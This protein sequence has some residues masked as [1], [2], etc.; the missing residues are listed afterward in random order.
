MSTFEGKAR[1]EF[2]PKKVGLFAAKV[3]AINPTA[4]E[5]PDLLGWPAKEDS[6]ETEYLGEDEEGNTKLRVNVWIEDVDTGT[7]FN[8]AFFL[9]NKERENKDFTK[10]QFINAVGACTWSADIRDLK[11]DETHKWFTKFEHRVAFVGEEELYTFIQS[12]LSRL[13]Y[14]SPETNLHIDDNWRMLMKGNVKFLKEQIG[15]EWCTDPKTG[16]AIPFL[17]L[18]TIR[19][20]D[21]DGETKEYQG[22][23]N[24]G[25]LPIRD[26]PHFRLTDYS[27]E[28]AVERIKAKNAKDRKRHEKFVLNLTGQYGCKDFYVLKELKDYDPS[29]NIVASDKVISEEG[30]DY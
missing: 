2:G 14:R 8:A 29:E 4:D 19:N 28:E 13:D 1:E 5:Y 10:K 25:F 6:K 21:K 16:E 23:Y 22:I 26:L 15:G 20:S 30:A 9:K 3:I 27:S 24:K 11:S 18:A 17:A 12:W 7:K